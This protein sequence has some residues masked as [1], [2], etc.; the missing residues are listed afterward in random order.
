MGARPAVRR[1]LEVGKEL[2]RS[3]DEMDERTRETLFG[4]KRRGQK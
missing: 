2:R 3:L 4:N 1:A